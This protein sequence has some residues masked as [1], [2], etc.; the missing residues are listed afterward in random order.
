M[1]TVRTAC[2]VHSDWSFDGQWPL[3]RIVETFQARGYRAVMMTEHDQG[4]DEARRREH[5]AACR[6]VSNENILLIPGIE[7]SD[8]TNT[9]H[10]L[11]WGD[12]PFIGEQVPTEKTI[13][14]AK[15]A[16][17]IVVLAHPSRR[18]AWKMF[19]PEWS[20]GLLGIEIWNRKTDGWAPSKDGQA[21]IEA[22]GLT[23]FV[24]L[25]FHSPKQFFP[26][27]MAMELESPVTEAAILNCM[28]AGRLSCEA[29]GRPVQAVSEGAG[30]V[31]LHTAEYMRRK[32]AALYHGVTD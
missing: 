9:I 28:K 29:F 12:V 2:H 20:G 30:A 27:A 19:K 4:F 21:L 5:V 17:G 24:G 13:E 14:A 1:T 11:V 23:P 18:A 16:G 7:Y 32:A 25:D 15:A 26:L 10:L 31:A 3:E 22:S 8:P 6:R